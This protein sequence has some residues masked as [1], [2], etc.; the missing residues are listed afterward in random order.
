IFLK[1][2]DPTCP[3]LP[4]L[5]EATV[6]A[7]LSATPDTARMGT[8]TVGQTGT[9]KVIV[10]GNKAFHITVIEDQADGVTAETSDVLGETHIVTIKWQPTAAGELKRQLVIK[11]DLDKDTSVT[12]PVEGTAVAPQ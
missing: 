11:T 10:K 7:P 3:L 12:V 9:Q 8:V 4:V 6:Q 2:N 5:V 1:T